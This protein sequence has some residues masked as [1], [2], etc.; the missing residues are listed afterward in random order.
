MKQIIIEFLNSFYDLKNFLKYSFKIKKLN[1]KSH[2]VAFLTKQ[3]HT[4]EKGLALPDIRLSFGKKKI[5][6][7]LTLTPKYIKSFGEDQLTENI[8]SVLEQYV[9]FHEAKN[10]N[11]EIIQKINLFVKKYKSSKNTGGV[12]PFVQ[13]NITSKEYELFIKSRASVRDFNETQVSEK[14]ILEAIEVAKYTPSVCNRQGWKVHIYQAEDAY[15]LLKL[16]NGSGGFRERIKTIAIITGDINYFSDNERNQIGIDS[17][18]FCMSF[19]L[20]LY[21]LGIA[22]CALNTC[23]SLKSEIRIKNRAS[24]P[25]NEKVIMYLALGY[26]SEGCVVA[27]SQRR[28]NESFVTFH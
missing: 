6:E 3:Y 20:S 10:V 26:P 9:L 7:I 17:G 13:P 21:S 14:S 27:K 12:R 22:S 28:S 25:E 24:I 19:I 15:E 4:I 8:I 5:E 23:V 1:D 2:Y 16:Q 18:M 11:N